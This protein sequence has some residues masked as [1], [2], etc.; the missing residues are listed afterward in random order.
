MS[1]NLSKNLNNKPL[2][3]D[4]DGVLL[5]WL[6]GFTFFVEKKQNLTL[7]KAGPQTFDLSEW[8]GCSKDEMI[9]LI[10]AFNSGEDGFFGQL[11]PLPLAVESLQAAYSIGRPIHV[12]TSVSKQPEVIAQRKSNLITVFGDIFTEINC[13]GLHSSKQ[14]HL[15]RH[16]DATWVEDHYDN[17]TVGA[18]AGHTSY[19]LRTSYNLRHEADCDTLIWVDDWSQIQEQENLLAA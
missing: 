8:L 15:A 17:A 5:D 9:A 6:G 18:K 12:I 19:L 1:K 7:C 2:L 16:Q 3:V 14:E 4:C 10:N 13:I 11:R